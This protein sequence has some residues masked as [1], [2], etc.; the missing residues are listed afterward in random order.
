MLLSKILNK[1]WLKYLPLSIILRCRALRTPNLIFFCILEPKILYF[2]TI[3]LG[4]SKD[5][6]IITLMSIKCD[7]RGN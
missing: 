2:L 7:Y 1:M 6:L 3:H 4:V 5:A